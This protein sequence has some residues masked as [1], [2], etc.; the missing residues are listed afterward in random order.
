MRRCSALLGMLVLAV[1]P[2]AVCVRGQQG[3]QGTAVRQAGEEEPAERL[4]EVLQLE[5]AFTDAVAMTVMQITRMFPEM[6]DHEYTLVDYVEE[7][8]SWD[9][10]RP[11][12]A[13]WY[14]EAFSAHELRELAEFHST[15]LGRKWVR[16]SPV[17]ALR[18][19]Q[20]VR[21]RLEADLEL[22]ELRMKNRELERLMEASVFFDSDPAP[23][24]R[25]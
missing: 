10:V 13:G 24:G 4:I 23:L 12:I 19:E 1:F 25:D 3:R 17:F 15:P 16:A 5:Q 11:L 21:D 8:L 20:L 14:N 7:R 9:G 18:M 6:Q 22:L 2:V